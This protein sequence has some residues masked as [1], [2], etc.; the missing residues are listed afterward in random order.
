M[1]SDAWFHGLTFYVCDECDIVDG[2]HIYYPKH[3]L[4]KRVWSQVCFGKICCIQCLKPAR[5]ARSGEYNLTRKLRVEV[6]TKESE[7]KDG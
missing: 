1:I 3:S 4:F 6:E 5:Q 7:G 2:Y